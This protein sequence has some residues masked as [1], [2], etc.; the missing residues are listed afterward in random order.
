MRIYYC[1]K[2]KM[3]Q[4]SFADAANIRLSLWTNKVY[5]RYYSQ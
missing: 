1:H 2:I 5:Y 4:T 3:V